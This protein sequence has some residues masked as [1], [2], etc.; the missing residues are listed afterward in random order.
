M[1]RAKIVRKPLIINHS[2]SIS[3]LPLL[4]NWELKTENK[5]PISM[6]LFSY[7]D[8]GEKLLHELKLHLKGQKKTNTIA[9]AIREYVK[10][11]VQLGGSIGKKS[12][13]D[14]IVELHKTATSPNT[15]SQ[16]V[17]IIKRYVSHLM[18]SE[19][20]PLETLSKTPLSGKKAAKASF[21]EL[22]SKDI[23]SLRLLT[24]KYQSEISSYVKKRGLEK[25]VALACFFSEKC[26]ETIHKLAVG[27][28]E[29]ALKDISF[30]DSIAQK[31]TQDEIEKYKRVTSL[32]NF[33][34]DTR[35]LREAF[36]ILYSHYL[37][38]NELPSSGKWPIG[39]S[40]YL[41]TRGW[42][43]RSVQ[44]EFKKI[45]EGESTILSEIVNTLSSAEIENYI[46]IT[47]WRVKSLNK[48]SVEICF[49]ILFSHYGYY[50]PRSTLW[51]HGIA[52]YLRKR[53]WPQSRVRSAIFPDTKIHE[54]LLLALLS[55]QELCPNVDSAFK[56]IY[57][58]S[59]MPAFEARRVRL[60]IG[61]RRGSAS[62]I[63]LAEKDPLISLMVKLIEYIKQRLASDK[64]G[65]ELLRQ[66][67]TSIFIHFNNMR[68]ENKI[69]IYD[70]ST[71]A[72]FVKRALERYSKTC[73]LL[74]CLSNHGVRGENFRPT[75][76]A[77]LKLKGVAQ[78]TIQ[79]KL[80]H[81]SSKTTEIYT[82]KVETS[83]LNSSKQKSFQEYLIH[84]AEAF[85]PD[86][87]EKNTKVKQDKSEKE[88]PERIMF[89]DQYSIAEWIAL[90]SKILE[91][92][93]RLSLCNPSRWFEY[94]VNKLAEIDGFLSLVSSKDYY[95][96]KKMS[97]SIVIPYLD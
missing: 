73:N 93:D 25:E 51:P 70:S 9:L 17:S 52:D 41:K 82:Q 89:Y 27:E 37:I 42:S 81:K 26:M 57:L 48:K 66:E 80:N 88:H 91:E 86:L 56:Y 54:P 74:E 28:V 58:D 53:G 79:K 72:D 8:D 90:K 14:Y 85:Q 23:S 19:V 31:I 63:D 61:K 55:H 49:K 77:I 34:S 24:D 44:A 29:I 22:V 62:D 87:L 67:H 97:E 59:I 15:L 95:V 5:A 65:F 35:T 30:F 69:S 43:I 10:Y 18:Y 46:N 71:S 12:L 38:S 78:H 94:W 13:D 60:I 3:E 50:P 1:A 92:K 16:K 36:E 21:F 45:Q 32:S 96:A 76:A 40:D 75:C 7:L 84:E 20:I 64:R 2:A 11:V 39:L 6:Y 47:D 83:T 33:Y 4:N 68:G